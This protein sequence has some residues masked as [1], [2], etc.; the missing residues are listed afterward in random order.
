MEKTPL[1][2]DVD[3]VL[4]VFAEGYQNRSVEVDGDNF[5]HLLYPSEHTLPFM[6]WA[7]AT[8]DV[9]WCTAWDKQ[10]N[11]IA[12]WAKLPQR[13]CVSDVKSKSAEWKLDAV[14]AFMDGRRSRAVWIEDGI[15]PV[16]D[17]WVARKKNF[18]YIHTAFRVGVTRDH[19]ACLADW[20]GLSMDAWR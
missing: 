16:A 7:W 12:D 1:F 4:N 18:F 9:Y 5:P 3:G 14:K 19:A 13:P 8:F 15:G 17:A 6:R 20:L 2:L 10:A 11:R